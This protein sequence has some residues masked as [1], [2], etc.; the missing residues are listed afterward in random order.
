MNVD[1]IIVLEQASDDI[2]EGKR[3][4]NINGIN[5]SDYFF[6]SILA[7]IESLKLYAGIHSKHVGLYRMLTK[8]FPFA[9][10]Y[11]IAETTV[12]VIAVLD[13]RRKPAWIRKKLPQ[14]L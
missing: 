13:S 5:V 2:T 12:V 6:D 11:D 14:P 3:F 7:D 10:Y 9:I 4:Y 8:R 1:N